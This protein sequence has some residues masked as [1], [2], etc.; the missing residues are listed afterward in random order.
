LE[1]IMDDWRTFLDRQAQTLIGSKVQAE[2]SKPVSKDPVTGV[3]YQDGQPAKT[4]ATSISPL[5]WVGGGVLVLGLL[6]VMLRK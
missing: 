6:F 4:A 3:T 2:I 1:A 5:V